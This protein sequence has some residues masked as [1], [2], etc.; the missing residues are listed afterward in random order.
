MSAVLL[1]HDLLESVHASFIP[2][3]P[4]QPFGVNFDLYGDRRQSST[5]A[6]R[7]FKIPHYKESHT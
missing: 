2:R 6:M 4:G 7:N 5:T 3:S 1:V